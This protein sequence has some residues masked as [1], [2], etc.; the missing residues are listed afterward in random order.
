MAACAGPAETP[1]SVPASAAVT[2]AATE[3][4]WSGTATP[5]ATATPAGPTAASPVT[6]RSALYGYSLEVPA[7]WSIGA[8]MLRWDGASQPG[9][10]DASVD[11][12]ASPSAVSAWAFSGPVTVDLA[13]FAKELIAWTVRDHGDTCPTTTPESTEP[14][15]VGGEAGML[16]SWN[17]G[18]LVN[19][20][21][22][23]RDGTGFVLVIRD[24]GVEAAT[25]PADR[26]LLDKLL[27]SVTL[28]T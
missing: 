4:S 25:D 16:L 8:A 22:T 5:K 7:G 21:V 15:Q 12:F 23:V 2:A 26:T 28:P 14:I 19:E 24:P 6:F 3:A 11:K 9:H 20:A 13:G 17:C 1:S 10:L 18:I 27:H